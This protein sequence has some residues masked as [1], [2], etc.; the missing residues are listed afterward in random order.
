MWSSV[1]RRL[2]SLPGQGGTGA[3][4]CLEEEGASKPRQALGKGWPASG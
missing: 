3:A 1:G 2:G 4:G